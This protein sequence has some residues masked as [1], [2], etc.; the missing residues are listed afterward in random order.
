M[1]LIDNVVVVLVHDLLDA[2]SDELI[3]NLVHFAKMI[4]S[5]K[6]ALTEVDVRDRAVTL[7]LLIDTH[8]LSA[9]IESE[10]SKDARS[11]VANISKVLIVSAFVLF[12]YSCS[13]FE[14][15][16]ESTDCSFSGLELSFGLV[17]S[18]TLEMCH[19]N[20]AQDFIAIAIVFLMGDAFDTDREI[21]HLDRLRLVHVHVDELALVE[22]PA[23]E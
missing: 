16:S 22:E 4:D 17:A 13:L 9:N 6:S 7:N 14:K 8:L 10:A 3:F 18:D 11:W 2:V 5:M 12:I 20:G 21:A 23:E 19:K 1:S 15:A